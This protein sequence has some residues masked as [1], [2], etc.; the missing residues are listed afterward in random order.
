[1]YIMKT[2]KTLVWTVIILFLGISVYPQNL[3]FK[4]VQGFKP[5]VEQFKN[6]YIDWGNGFYYTVSKGYPPV[7]KRRRRRGGMSL[8]LQKVKAKQAAIEGAKAQILLMA[9]K[10]RV[11]ADA[12]VGDLT[13]AGYTIKVEGEVKNL[14]VPDHLQGWV[15]DPRRPYY[16]VVVK[17]PISGVSSQLISSQ[18]TKIRTGRRG[19]VKPPEPEKKEPEKKE[20]PKEEEKAPEEKKPEK[21]TKEEKIDDIRKKAED[22]EKEMLLLIDARDTGAKQA[23]FP[24]IKDEDGADIFNITLP[25][26]V[27]V[28][29]EQ[30][31]KYVKTDKKKEA[32]INEIRGHSDILYVSALPPKQTIVFSERHHAVL[33]AGNGKP[34]KKP[35]RR[36]RRFA[37]RAQSSAGKLKANIVISRKDAKKIIKADKKA[38]FFR[39]AN[40]Y[41]IMDSSIGGT[42]G[43]IPE[44]LDSVL[45]EIQHGSNT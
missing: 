43:S 13:A 9:N 35:R 28:K 40:V 34:A 1:M 19:E 42:E 38:E 36:R 26:K 21:K 27:K 18:I 31:V 14:E 39:K 8:A 24:E 17:A 2:Y 22:A 11:D 45:A 41:V 12:T 15:N 29:H 33:T 16:E 3:E 25:D 5:S 6:G 7:Q 44:L 20:E 23:V 37:C 30:M 10:I 32:I 4:R